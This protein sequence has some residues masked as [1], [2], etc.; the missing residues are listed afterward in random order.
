MAGK[1]GNPRTPAL[2]GFRL[3]RR[4]KTKHC[5]GKQNIGEDS[6]HSSPRHLEEGLLLV[7]L[8]AYTSPTRVVGH[9]EAWRVCPFPGAPKRRWRRAAFG[10]D[11]L[12]SGELW[13]GMKSVL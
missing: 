11:Y 5:T 12:E 1:L 6:R 4:P 13:A 3:A 7:D 10:I 8:R 9:V 2:P